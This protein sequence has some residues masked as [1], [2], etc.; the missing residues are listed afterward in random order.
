MYNT[1]I[2]ILYLFTHLHVMIVIYY[3]DML[4]ISSYLYHSIHIYIA[5]RS[6]LFSS[7]GANIVQPNLSGFARSESCSTLWN[8]GSFVGRVRILYMTDN[9]HRADKRNAIL[10]CAICECVS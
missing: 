4:Y 9:G 6:P 5:T 3:I 10:M 1:P 2:N 8:I 7:V